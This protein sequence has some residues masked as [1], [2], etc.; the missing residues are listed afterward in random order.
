MYL[1]NI[2]MK[3]RSIKNSKVGIMCV[4]MLLAPIQIIRFQ[5]C[6]FLESNIKYLSFISSII[7]LF[8]V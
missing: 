3:S 7:I 8:S 6:Y 2:V 5:N 4:E 1:V